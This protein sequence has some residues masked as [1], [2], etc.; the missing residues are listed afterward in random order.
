MPYVVVCHLSVFL[1]VTFMHPTLPVEMFGNVST[2]FG[3]LAIHW[4]PGKFLWRYPAEPFCHGVKHK[5][6]SQI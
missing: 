6:G 1:S 5:R 2:P 3:T 4:Y